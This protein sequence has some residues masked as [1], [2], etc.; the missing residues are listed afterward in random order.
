MKDFY[1]R[2]SQK[3]GEDPKLGYLPSVMFIY[4][5]NK[6]PLSRPTLFAS[7]DGIMYNFVRN[8]KSA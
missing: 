7:V 8:E 2:E 1:L 4:Y 3:N 5:R 6:N